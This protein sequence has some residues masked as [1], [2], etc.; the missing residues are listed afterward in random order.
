MIRRA[1]FA[2]VLVMWGDYAAFQIMA[3]IMLS[4]VILMYQILVKPFE[5][6]KLNRL[7]VF[8]ELTVLVCSWHLLIFSDLVNDINV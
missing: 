1:L 5:E 6:R 2:I 7:E 3:V 4:L 8:N